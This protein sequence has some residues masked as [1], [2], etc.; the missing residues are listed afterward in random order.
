[1]GKALLDRLRGARYVELF[2]A[3]VL[4]ALLALLLLGKSGTESGEGRTEL[5]A[6]MERILSDIDGVGRV[7]VMI[8]ENEGG[9]AVGALVVA[10]GLED[11]QAFLSLQS[12]VSTL[13]ELETDRIEIIA[14]DGRFGGRK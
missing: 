11:I 14:G 4:L 9:R 10:D 5:E 2:V 1:M 7:S 8:T 3:L 6:R 13:L 12:A